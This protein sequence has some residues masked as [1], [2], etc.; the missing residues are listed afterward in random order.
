MDLELLITLILRIIVSFACGG[1]LLRSWLRSK[2]R[3][4]SDF[5]FVFSLMF[6]TL[7]VAKIIDAFIAAAFVPGDPSMAFLSWIRLRYSVMA[8]NTIEMLAIILIIWF[9]SKRK[10][11]ILIFSGYSLAWILVLLVA[12]SYETISKTLSYLVVP[13]MI[14]LIFTFVFTYRQKRLVN[15]FN[16]LVVAIGTIIYAASQFIR[17]SLTNM[18]SSAWGLTWLSELIDLIAWA[19]IFWG[20]FKPAM[21]IKKDAEYQEEIVA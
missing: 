19:L 12:S 3:F 20:F 10:A 21:P 11:S 15:K 9:R 14:A 16:S 6:F 13:V 18:G 17:P 7:A 1:L 4:F 2:K 8:I 5:P